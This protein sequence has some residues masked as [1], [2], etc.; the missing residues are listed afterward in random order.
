MDRHTFTDE[1]GRALRGKISDA[2]LT[3]HIRYYEDYIA[4]EMASGR[5]EEEILAELGDPRL[6]ARTIVDTAGGRTSHTEYTVSEDGYEET[7]SEQRVYNLNGW[8]GKLFVCGLLVVLFLIFVVVFHIV[9]ALLPILI[10]LGLVGWLFR[11][12]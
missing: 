11:R 2:E 10:V 3:G 12:R 1:L 8:R 6:I 9:A 4:Q 7:R 5:G